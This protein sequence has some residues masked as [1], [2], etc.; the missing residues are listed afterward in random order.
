MLARDLGGKGAVVPMRACFNVLVFLW[1]LL[2]GGCAM[3]AMS[4]QIWPYESARATEDVRTN[5][6]VDSIVAASRDESGTVTICVT[7]HWDG[8]GESRRQF[9]YIFPTKRDWKDNLPSELKT[10][11]REDAPVH[12]IVA[13][14]FGNSCDVSGAGGN[15]N[16]RALPIEEI[17][18]SEV[19]DELSRQADVISFNGEEPEPAMYFERFAK[20]PAVYKF[21]A[22]ADAD[23]FAIIYVHEKM[24]FRDSRAADVRSYAKVKKKVQG[25][26]I[27]ILTLPFA[28]VIDL[29]MLPVWLFTGALAHSS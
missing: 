11:G 23:R 29:V 18:L 10:S 25:N 5:E 26:Y 15:L 28:F 27:Y 24:I 8:K 6:I 2:T 17:T 9:S 20:N 7:G 4:E 13:A 3:R 14:K 19:N 22:R 1:L 21:R 16:R 12:R